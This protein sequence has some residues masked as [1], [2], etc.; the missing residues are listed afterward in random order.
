MRN[1]TF[2]HLQSYPQGLGSVRVCMDLWIYEQLYNKYFIGEMV[3]KLLTSFRSTFA[4]QR[5]IFKWVNQ[6]FTT[7]KQSLILLSRETHTTVLHSDSILEVEKI[8]ALSS[9][10]I[11]I[12]M[13]SLI[14]TPNY[15]VFDIFA[16][17]FYIQI[18][19]QFYNGFTFRFKSRGEKNNSTFIHVIYPHELFNSHP[20]LFYIWYICLSY[21]ER[22]RTPL[23]S[24]GKLVF[25]EA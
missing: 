2:A 1:L 22:S 7:P 5:Q 11:Y 9:T 4:S 18:Y 12:H 25:A 21:W 19:I 23:H 14:V 10:C 15:F 8:T 20:K 6:E 16:C 24:C 13:S 17:R 3:I